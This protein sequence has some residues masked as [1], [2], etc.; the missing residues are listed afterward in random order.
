MK[1]S[2]PPVHYANDALR[3][4]TGSLLVQN[5]PFDVVITLRNPYIFDLELSKL[6]LRSVTTFSLSLCCSLIVQHFWRGHR[7]EVYG[8]SRPC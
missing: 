4:Q 2:N 3:P 6:S 7:V 5:E 8:S 1:F